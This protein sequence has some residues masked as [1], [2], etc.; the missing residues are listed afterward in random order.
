MNSTIPAR[1]A[2]TCGCGRTHHDHASALTFW[3]IQTFGTFDPAVLVLLNCRC[4][5]TLA[6]TMDSVL[7][8]DGGLR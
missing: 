5:S 7:H 3:G 6:P 1:P 4:N 8:D 2:L